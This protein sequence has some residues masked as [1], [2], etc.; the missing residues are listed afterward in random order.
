MSVG[1]FFFLHPPFLN[2][3]YVVLFMRFF[4]Y[5]LSKGRDDLRQDAVMQQVF[6]MCNALL[7]K[8][9][10]TRKRKLTI[11][12]Y[13][14]IFTSFSNWLYISTY[15]HIY[16]IS[17]H[18]NFAVK[19]SALYIVFINYVDSPKRNFYAE[20]WLFRLLL[21]IFFSPKHPGLL[22]FAFCFVLMVCY[23]WMYFICFNWSSLSGNS[24]ETKHCETRWFYLHVAPYCNCLI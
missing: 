4:L 8:N 21:Y 13:K 17:N 14:V 11:R 1:T 22:Y 18:Q 15:L 2:S 16:Y 7:Q 5:V 23:C 12:R 20:M 19:S 3:L 6:Q 10:E 9:S 24:V